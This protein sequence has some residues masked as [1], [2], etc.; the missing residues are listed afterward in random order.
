MCGNAQNKQFFIKEGI[1]RKAHWNDFFQEENIDKGTKMTKALGSFDKSNTLYT[2][3]E[4]IDKSIISK[5]KSKETSLKFINKMLDKEAIPI[6]EL[7][8][9]AKEEEKISGKIVDYWSIRNERGRLGVFFVTTNGIAYILEDSESAP[10]GAM[11]G[12]VAIGP[13]GAILGYIGQGVYH[14]IKFKS[15][16]LTKK[17]LIMIDR[18]KKY[19]TSLASKCYKEGIFISF[20]KIHEMIYNKK[21]KAISIRFGDKYARKFYF[22]VDDFIK[23]ESIFNSSSSPSGH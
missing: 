7:N 6:D 22:R 18:A 20:D 23:M 11:G 19:S 10:Y 5:I 12:L 21:K 17:Q 13:A 1:Q 9:I 16:K 8:K 4:R 14:S 15:K 2:P 3:F